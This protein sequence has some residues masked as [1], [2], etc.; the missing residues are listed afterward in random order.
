MDA[1]KLI[2]EKTGNTEFC[3]CGKCGMVHLTESDA[4]ACCERK[5]ASA[6]LR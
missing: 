5:H 2:N 3:K 4:N 6:D 1:I